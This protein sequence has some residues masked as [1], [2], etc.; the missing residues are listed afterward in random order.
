MNNRYSAHKILGHPVKLAS[1][2]T[3]TITAPL[4]VRIKPINR[5]NHACR[6]CT[7]KA[8][9]RGADGDPHM[10]VLDSGMH[11]EMNE[12]DT[13]TDAKLIELIN[14][15]ADMGVKA[16][17]FSGGGEPL[18]HRAIVPAMADTVTRGMD[19]SIITNGQ[20]LSGERAKVLRHAKWVRVSMDYTTAAQMADS[21]VV[22]E[23]LFDQVLG[24]LRDF[25]EMAPACDLGVNFIVHRGNCDG[26]AQFTHELKALGVRNVRFSPLHVP[27]LNAYH[28]PI[29]PTVL[30][31]LALA[32]S[33]EDATFQV[34]STYDLNDVAHGTERPYEWC[35]YMQT[36][37]VAGADLN[38]YACHN[39]AYD[40]TGIVASFANR[41]FS[42]AWFSEEAAH[43][44]KHL[45]PP[46]MCQHQCAND[47]KNRFIHDVLKPGDN[48]V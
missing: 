43:A 20:L 41:K 31:Q 38:I 26:L 35:P 7:Y 27:E 32:K 18:L 36:V 8:D 48:F 37:P 10:E 40:A 44:F 22:S 15:L 12:A 5:C 14:D 24:N 17:T 33:L 1:F 23:R 45:H 3:R 2:A 28:A 29:L 47:H 30:A 25:A 46:T 16:V 39:K 34:H 21:R 13:M 6:W 19:L 9:R 11:T 4:Y 42:E